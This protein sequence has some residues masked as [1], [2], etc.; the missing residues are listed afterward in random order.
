MNHILTPLSCPAGP[1]PG[2]PVAVSLGIDDRPNPVVYLADA[3]AFAPNAPRLDV[4][5]EGHI[6]ATI[7]RERKVITLAPKPGS[8]RAWDVRQIGWT[9]EIDEML[10][11]CHSVGS[12][13]FRQEDDK[14]FACWSYLSDLW[15]RA[16]M[17][18]R[19][20]QAQAA[21][22]I[23]EAKDVHSRSSRDF[24]DWHDGK[25][26]ESDLIAAAFK[27]RVFPDSDR[28]E[29]SGGDVSF[30]LDVAHPPYIRPGDKT[31]YLCYMKSRPITVGMMVLCVTLPED[32]DPKGAKVE[33]LL[34][35]YCHDDYCFEGVKYVDRRGETIPEHRRRA[36]GAAVAYTPKEGGKA[37]HSYDG[38]R[39]LWGEKPENR[40]QA[41]QYRNKWHRFQGER[42]LFRCHDRMALGDMAFF[43]DVAIGGE[44]TD[45][46]RDHYHEKTGKPYVQGIR[47]NL[48]PSWSPTFHSAK[49][50]ITKE[51]PKPG[52]LF[53]AAFVDQVEH[54]DGQPAYTDHATDLAVLM[55]DGDTVICGHSAPRPLS[56]V[57]VI[58]HLIELEF[59]KRSIPAPTID[60]EQLAYGVPEKRADVRPGRF[61]DMA[62]GD[63]RAAYEDGPIYIAGQEP[64]QIGFGSILYR[65]LVT[66]EGENYRVE[67]QACFDHAPYRW[68]P[69]TLNSSDE[70]SEVCGLVDLETVVAYHTY[71]VRKSAAIDR[72]DGAA[73]AMVRGATLEALKAQWAVAAERASVPSVTA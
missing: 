42:M 19:M 6:V 34:A 2:T 21:M 10:A 43:L 53:Y 70:L 27:G 13:S 12:E 49:V 37:Q 69:T 16:P 5:D 38:I 29:T 20:T 68:T 62:D 32:M 50:T 47:W 24:G 57:R 41:A 23:F 7:D 63:D 11:F 54:E 66:R 30:V 67:V 51:T 71:S 31:E 15:W 28:V 40:T 36:I 39:F 64:D 1:G 8:A 9:E 14:W 22:R 65:V 44:G 56:E 58:G 46:E 35:E 33:P 72:R 17:K 55:A 73:E 45:R 18:G 25:Y 61:A 3:M 26:I 59:D 52:Q 4:Y 60:V 48:I